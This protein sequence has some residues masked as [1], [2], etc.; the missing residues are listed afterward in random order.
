MLFEKAEENK[1]MQAGLDPLE[2]RLEVDTVYKDLINIEK[3]IELSRQRGAGLLDEE[4][5]DHRRTLEMIV[6]L[7]KEIQG[8]SGADVRRVFAR[9]GEQLADQLEKIRGHEMRINK[10]HRN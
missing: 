5:E 6:E 2:W 7:C 3:E 4:I 10:E 9:V 8:S 1:I